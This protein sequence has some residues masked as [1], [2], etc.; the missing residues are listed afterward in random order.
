MRSP[1]GESDSRELQKEAQKIAET[2][3]NEGSLAAAEMIMGLPGGAVVME[4]DK[5]GKVKTGRYVPP[6]KNEK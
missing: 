6:Q 5:E 3:A 4:F 1:E 2:Y